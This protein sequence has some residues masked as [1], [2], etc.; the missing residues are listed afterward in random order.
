[1]EKQPF[2]KL[3]IISFLASFISKIKIAD[4]FNFVSVKYFDKRL[5]FLKIYHNLKLRVVKVNCH[6]SKVN[7]GCLSPSILRWTPF[8][9]CSPFLFVEWT[10]PH[11]GHWNSPMLWSFHQTK[12]TTICS[13]LYEPIFVMR[14]IFN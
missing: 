13:A 12:V 3:K 14:C 10:T 9:S 4:I 5:L 6:Q 8:V 2:K 7:R 1:M 11:C